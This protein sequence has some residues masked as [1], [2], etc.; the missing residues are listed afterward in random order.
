MTFPGTFDIDHWFEEVF[1]HIASDGTYARTALFPANNQG[2]EPATLRAVKDGH[3]LPA[4]GERHGV[5]NIYLSEAQYQAA[6]SS[7]RSGKR[8]EF[9]YDGRPDSGYLRQYS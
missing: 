4:N 7:L 9:R 6:M 8:V 2:N 3:A 1:N 5:V